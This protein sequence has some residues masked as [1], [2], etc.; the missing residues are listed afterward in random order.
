MEPLRIVTINT[1]KCD[2]PYRARI[3]WM[4]EEV[5]RLRPDVLL[6]QEVFREDG[7]DRDT[8]EALKRGLGLQA[9][10]APARNKKRQSEGEAVAGWS[11]MAMLSRRPWAYVDILELPGDDRDGDRVAQVGVLELGE[12]SVVVANV[13]LTYVPDG[14]ELRECQL[15]AVLS[16]PLLKMRQAMRLICGDFNSRHD[17]EWMSRIL[18]TSAEGSLIDCYV[19][20]RGASERSTLAPREASAGV[21]PCVDF[22]LSLAQDAESHPVFRSS[23]VVMKNP[24]PKTG[25]LPSDHYGVAT[26]LM[27]LRMPAWRREQTLVT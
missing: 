23:A 19:A 9:A 21:R 14:D 16:H 12:S 27:P 15:Q 24:D 17:G 20:G 6:C 8:L 4:V 1:A 18:A 11:G 22:I 26:T 25:T 3:A 13:H 7:G 10:W 2:G 5:R